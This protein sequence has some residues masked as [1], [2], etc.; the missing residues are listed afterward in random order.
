VR[1]LTLRE[2]IALSLQNNLTLKAR[3]LSPQIA[4]F[5]VKA[6]YGAFDPALTLQANRAFDNQPADYKVDKINNEGNLVVGAPVVP[7]LVS[8]AIPNPNNLVNG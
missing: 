1:S 3:Q 4:A 2:C 7:P 6:A 8:G 5:E